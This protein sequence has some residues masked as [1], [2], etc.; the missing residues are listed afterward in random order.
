MGYGATVVACRV[1][2]SVMAQSAHE[3]NQ[4]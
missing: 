4:A 3:S 1:E 2:M